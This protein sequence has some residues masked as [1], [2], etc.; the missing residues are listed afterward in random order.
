MAQA[1]LR[2]DYEHN[3]ASS[4]G[5]DDLAHDTQEQYPLHTRQLARL[6]AG[7]TGQA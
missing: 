5:W 3:R 2:H 4:P 6:H 7:E 1:L